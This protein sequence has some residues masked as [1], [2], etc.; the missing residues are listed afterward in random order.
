AFTELLFSGYC[1]SQWGGQLSLT[2]TDTEPEP[3]WTEAAGV[4]PGIVGGSASSA[5]SR[6][7]SLP[8]VGQAEPGGRSRGSAS[9]QLSWLH[10]I[11]IRLL[12]NVFS[13]PPESRAV[14]I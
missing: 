12:C 3:G 11:C 2:L 8:S 9:R 1:R 7:P 6:A 13:A 10:R 14:N 4:I 5:P